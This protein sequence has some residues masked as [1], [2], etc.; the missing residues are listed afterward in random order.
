VGK[1]CLEKQQWE[2][3]LANLKQAMT[4]GYYTAE[5]LNCLAR[6][7]IGLGHEMEAVGYL[8]K[9]LALNSNQPE[10]QKLLETYKK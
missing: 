6:A 2:K 9:S 5:L 8:E 1:W 4:L 3:A 10:I 7:E